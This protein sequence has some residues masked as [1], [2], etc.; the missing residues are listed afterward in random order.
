MTFLIVHKIFYTIPCRY[1]PG[2]KKRQLQDQLK[3]KEVG[4]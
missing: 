1:V 2:K 3:G 4:M